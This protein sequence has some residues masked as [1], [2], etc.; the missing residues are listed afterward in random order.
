MVTSFN[1]P[2]PLPASLLALRRIRFPRKL[3][4]CDRLFGASLAR[5][6]IAWVR[7]AAGPVWKLDLANTTHRWLVYG[8]YEGPA[9]WRWLE[10]N[11]PLRD[12]IVDSGANIGQTVLT[13]ASQFPSTRI[14]A[15]EPGAA[16]REW[17]A[18]GVRENKL[19]AVTIR[20]VGLGA[21]PSQAR[22]ASAGSSSSHGS[23]NR[24]SQ[25][26]GE[27]IELNT[28]D[29]ELSELGIETI[30]FW[31]LDMEGYELEAIRGARS[32]LSR[33]AVRAIYAEIGCPEESEVFRTLADHGYSAHR[34][35]PDGSLRPCRSVAAYESALFLAPGHPAASR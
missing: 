19:D 13:F 29:R 30:G 11:P 1:S 3:G 6:G 21:S 17:L 8:D 5:H 28:M 24:I 35:M 10:K 4:F 18:Q 14:F 25:S 33:H 16:A 34:I 12:P 20:P 26:E 31:K 9:L 23:W 15:Y 27:T 2:L 7:T 32:A 22:L